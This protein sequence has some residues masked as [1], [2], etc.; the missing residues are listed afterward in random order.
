MRFFLWNFCFE[1]K[2][3]KISGK[4]TSSTSYIDINFQFLLAF[5]LSDAVFLLVKIY[6]CLVIH[7]RKVRYPSLCEWEI[8]KYGS[9]YLNATV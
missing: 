7:E 5:D 6:L 3:H 2:W 9:V 8:E 4:K 1:T